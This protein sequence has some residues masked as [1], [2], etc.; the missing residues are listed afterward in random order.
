[1]SAITTITHQRRP[2]KDDSVASFTSEKHQ[3]VSEIEHKLEPFARALLADLQIAA[4]SVA[5]ATQGRK[6]SDYLWIFLCIKSRHGKLP[7]KFQY[8]KP[9]K[10]VADL[11]KTN[12][13]VRIDFH[14][15]PPR[16]DLLEMTMILNCAA[17]RSLFK[18][19]LGS[20]M[21]VP[22]LV[23]TDW[24]DVW[25]V[26]S[27]VD[28]KALLTLDLADLKIVH[29]KIDLYWASALTWAKLRTDTFE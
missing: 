1:M 28:L 23:N 16:V 14:S 17:W 24:D 5:N 12:A 26:S 18:K 20:A 8:F 9:L 13:R 11:Y 27:E 29:S 10:D 21:P 2:I 25:L 7:A 6:V 4:Q 19:E 22:F 3:I 15:F